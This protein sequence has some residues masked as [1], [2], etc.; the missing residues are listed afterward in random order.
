MQSE[1][2]SIGS[3]AKKSQDP[4]G[5]L[6]S[7]PRHSL[8]GHTGPANCVAFHPKFSSIATGSDDCSIKIWDWE[9]GELER[10]IKGH[11]QPIRDLDY[12][13]SASGL[14]ASCSSDLTI[15]LWDPQNGYK[16]T[17]TLQGHEHS[18][19]AIRQVA[20]KFSGSKTNYVLLSSSGDQTIKIWDIDS[21]ACI[22]TLGGHTDWVRDI[23]S[24]NNGRFV[25]SASSDHTARLWD[26]SDSSPHSFV[27]LSGHEHVITCCAF[28]PTSSHRYLAE[29]PKTKTGSSEADIG[30]MATGSRD[31]TLKIWN[32]QAQCVLTLRGHGN[33]INGLAFHPGGQYLLSVADDKTI[34]CWDLANEGKCVKVLEG[35]HKQFITSVR[36]ACALKSSSSEGEGDLR[37]QPTKANQVEQIRCVVATAGMDSVVKVFLI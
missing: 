37:A 25:L 35:I 13:A 31:K 16:N 30:F 21:G 7:T 34:R 14:L 4:R 23:S 8:E 22:R 29:L 10:T 19:T 5:W 1:L 33:W 36:W 2:D 26:L 18:V 15:K 27:M 20:T 12:G 9:F 3:S 32:S 17:R 11:T 6:P 24:T 28:A